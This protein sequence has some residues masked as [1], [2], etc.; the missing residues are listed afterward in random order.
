MLTP[1]VRTIFLTVFLMILNIQCNSADQQ[2]S[3]DCKVTWSM[4]QVFLKDT[5][6]KKV[7]E[8]LD[9]QLMLCYLQDSGNLKVLNKLRITK[10]HKHEFEFLINRLYPKLYKDQ[11]KYQYELS[12][13]LEFKRDTTA[14]CSMLSDIELLLRQTDFNDIQN[15]DKLMT[16]I[17]IIY[18]LN[19]EDY[20]RSFIKNE[21]RNEAVLEHIKD[22]KSMLKTMS[23]W[24]TLNL[25]CK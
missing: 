18:Q 6:N 24:H 10:A 15:V 7:L 17:D 8:T 21:L 3:Y 4:M 12:K 5:G 9:S 25:K 22:V 11:W 14:L 20:T 13:I 2:R 16:Y 19:G 1:L 23:K